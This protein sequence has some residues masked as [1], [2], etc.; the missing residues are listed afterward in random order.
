MKLTIED[1]HGRKVVIETK[2]D[3]LNMDQVVEELVRPALIAYGFNSET[4]E[5]IF[6]EA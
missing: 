4:V 5:S 3:D 2:H 1:N 6:P